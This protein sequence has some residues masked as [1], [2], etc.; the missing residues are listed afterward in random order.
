MWQ[1]L[2]AVF[3]LRQICLRELLLRRV[4]ELELALASA[5]PGPAQLVGVLP[6]G[7][8]LPEGIASMRRSTIRYASSSSV[9]KITI[10][11]I[12]IAIGWVKSNV[13]AAARRILSGS[14]KSAS[15]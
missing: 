4:G 1:L 3:E 5:C 9:M 2:P 8:S 14:R 15:M 6:T 12:V 11:S 13:C 10:P 7:P